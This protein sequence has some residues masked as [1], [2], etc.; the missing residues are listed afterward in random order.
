MAGLLH[1]PAGLVV[2][3]LVLASV[4]FAGADL[5]HAATGNALAAAVAPTVGRGK[6]LSY[7]QYSFTF[8][9]VLVPA[10]FAQL[11]EVRE[12][13]P[14]VALSVLALVAGGTIV[15]LERVLPHAVTQRT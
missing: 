15:V 7:W 10:F 13:L 9:S 14:W 12:E 3:G 8:A 2:P 4:V 6:Y 11:F 5:L 1:V